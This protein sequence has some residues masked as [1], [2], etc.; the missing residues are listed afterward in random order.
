MHLLELGLI[1]CSPLWSVSHRLLL[2]FIKLS[3]S[4]VFLSILFRVAK[5]IIQNL[6]SGFV[7]VSLRTV[8]F[9]ATSLFIIF[10]FLANSSSVSFSC[11]NQAKTLPSPSS[12]ASEFT[13]LSY[14]PLSSMWNW[15]F[16]NP[17]LRVFL[18]CSQKII[19]LLVATPWLFPIYFSFISL[20]SGLFIK[21]TSWG[22]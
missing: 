17:Q 7:S 4:L 16:L 3:K 11:L 12:G 19:S 10:Y 18:P 21:Y 9:F 22:Y 8:R 1:H 14:N 2:G 5:A 20:H 6:F 15:T 13:C